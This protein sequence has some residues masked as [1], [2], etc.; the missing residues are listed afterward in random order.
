[1]LLLLVLALSALLTL[2]ETG[3]VN[4]LVVRHCAHRAGVDDASLNAV[5]FQA[6]KGTR[7]LVAAPHDPDKVY[8]MV[9]R[10][11]VMEDIEQVLSHSN[12]LNC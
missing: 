3:S 10:L 6:G 5:L 8:F 7:A 9:Q 2:H 4:T 12:H 11:Q 1:M